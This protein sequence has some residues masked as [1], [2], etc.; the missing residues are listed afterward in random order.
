MNSKLRPFVAVGMLATTAGFLNSGC[1]DNNATLFIQGVMKA[2]PPECEVKADQSAVMLGGGMLDV[3][4]RNTYTAALLVGNQYT[5][6]GDKENL[7]AETTRVNLRG[8]EVTLT[9]AEGNSVGCTADPGNAG[10]C[11]GFSN[12]FSV[13]G[14][15][16]ASASRG[17]E[18]GYGVFFADLIPETVG[19]SLARGLATGSTT[20][21]IATVR[22]FGDTTGGQEIESGELTFP[23][24]IC[25]GCL[26]NFPL[27]ALDRT[28]NGDTCT[29]KVDGVGDEPCDMGQDEAIDCRHC[30]YTHPVLCRGIIP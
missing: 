5:P 14:S 24:T 10:A 28:V 26:V 8:A 12:E 9:D 6:R 13:Y 7:R 30:A 18:A 17:A 19:A 2:K 3:A 27:E 25:N 21:V 16:F 22:V 1:A 29:L 15:G 11:S 4:F 23:I 20:T